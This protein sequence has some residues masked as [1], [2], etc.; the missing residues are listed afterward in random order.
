METSILRTEKMYN[1][2]MCD[3]EM[4]C[5]HVNSEM[6]PYAGFGVSCDETSSLLLWRW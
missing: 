2:K 6:L 1:I 4:A 5:E 3:G